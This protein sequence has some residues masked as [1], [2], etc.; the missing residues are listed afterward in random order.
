L[1]PA[2]GG[3]GSGTGF[4]QRAA[5]LRAANSS[6]AVRST[7]AV[8]GLYALDSEFQQTRAQLGRVSGQ[9]L[10]LERE[11]AQ[12]RTELRLTRRAYAFAQRQLALR[13]HDLYEQ[14]DSNTLAVFLGARSLDEAMMQID[15]LNRAASLN[16]AAVG[17]TES[18]RRSLVKLA[19]TLAA[20]DARLRR[21]RADVA[22]TAARLAG[23]RAERVH[24]LAALSRQRALNRHEIAALESQARSIAARAQQ[25]A[26]ARA[27]VSADPAAGS[28]PAGPRTL[29]VTATGYSMAGSTATGAPV[30]RGV[31]AVD[32]SVIPLG[33]RLTIPG[34]GSGVAADTGS[35]VSGTTI[36]LWFP[37]QVQALAWG[38][39]V[40]AITIL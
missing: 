32:P 1:I 5:E 35:A 23:A 21:L 13:L 9:A 2:A 6:L 25:V 28:G 39:R 3:A 16:A 11:R 14:G 34:Y 31:V 24:F 20:R 29:T 30:G 17:Q 18:T 10:R 38:R 26:A 12:V 22:A 27:T 33:S 19:A 40:V 37:S 4:K 36:D 15:D 7:S 8:L